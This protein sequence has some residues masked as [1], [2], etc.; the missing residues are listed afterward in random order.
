MS[1]PAA[2]SRRRVLATTAAAG[3]AVVG[4]AAC[5]SLVGSRPAGPPAADADLPR[6]SGPPLQRGTVHDVRAAGATGDGVTDDAA[7]F[8]R[9]LAGA[10]AGDTVFVPAG[11]Y[12]LVLPQ[13][14]T[15]P[16]G[17]LF[18][19]EPGRSVL[20][21]TPRA[22]AAIDVA[23]A[24]CALDGLELARAGDVET[25]LLRVGRF[26]RLTLSRLVFSGAVDVWESFCHGVQ[27]GVDGDTSTALVLRDSLFHRLTYGLYQANDSSAVTTGVDVTGCTFAFDANTD[28][29]FN[30]PGGS[31]RG[32]RVQ[33]CTFRDNDSPG[34]A[35]GVAY[36]AD[37]TVSRCT[38][39]NY[40]ME[41]VHVEDWS[42]DVVVTG[43]R[44]TACGLSEFA[45]VQI[46]QG[47]TRVV[48]RGNDFDATPN[49]SDIAVV[50]A[51]AGGRGSTA[52]G[53]PVVP[54]TAVTV[55]GNVFRCSDDVQAVA[56][57]GVDGGSITGNRVSG[58]SLDDA[59]LLDDVTRVAVGS[60]STV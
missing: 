18:A 46:I 48:V 5:A 38:M 11:T 4:T 50:N 55:T 7:A 52:G 47:C 34:F 14:L 23:G 45:F 60:N 59:L 26:D 54:P 27:L 6:P 41:A 49:T 1:P 8:A 9:A 58:P 15:L 3:A 25:V 28:L 43:N 57:H 2:L 32:V 29:E 21:M 33:D 37:V 44:M 51:L 31:F 17:V 16:A 40:R 53:R 19:G 24:D 13:P 36:C 12:H 56:F 35:V 20:R 10:A 22:T 39:T 30:S 42:S